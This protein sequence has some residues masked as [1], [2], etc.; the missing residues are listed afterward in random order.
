M[1]V[2]LLLAQLQRDDLL[3]VETRTVARWNSDIV[4]RI[5]GLAWLNE[6]RRAVSANVISCCFIIS[7][8]SAPLHVS[9]HSKVVRLH[10]CM[11][12]YIYQNTINFPDIKAACMSSLAPISRTAGF[13]LNVLIKKKRILFTARLCRT[14]WSPLCLIFKIFFPRVL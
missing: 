3:L 9:R 5:S 2:V 7:V 8:S 11:H 1:Q 4:W 13:Q 10:V 12:E 14:L 6:L